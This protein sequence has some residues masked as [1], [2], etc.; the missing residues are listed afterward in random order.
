MDLNK[1]NRNKVISLSFLSVAFFYLLIYIG[2][3]YHTVIQKIP[4]ESELYY[5]VKKMEDLHYF[6]FL[7]AIVTVLFMIKQNKTNTVVS[8]K[9][10]TDNLTGAYNRDYLDAFF[11]KKK[12]QDYVFVMI[13]IDHFKKINDN[14]GHDVGDVVLRGMIKEI[15]RVIRSGSEDRIIRFGGEEFLLLLHI[16]SVNGSSNGIMKTIERVRSAV[17][18]IEFEDGKNGT[19]EITASYGANFISHKCISVDEAIAL[20]DKA[21][22]KAKV[23]RDCIMTYEVSH[24]REHDIDFKK[25]EDLVN[26]GKLLCFYQPVVELKTG[27]VIKYEALVRLEDEAGTI[28]TPGSFLHIVNN[29]KIR[30]KIISSLF[31][32]N[33]R[34]L[35]QNKGM[36]ISINLSLAEIYDD[37]VF[38]YIISFRH[39]SSTSAS[40]IEL[41]ILDVDDANNVDLLEERLL[42][43]KQL[44]FKI[45]IDDFGG[46]YSRIMHLLETCVDELKIDGSIVKTLKHSNDNIEHIKSIVKMAHL[47]GLSVTAG[48]I[49]DKNIEKIL[50]DAG[51]DQ[52]QGFY[53]GK[54]VRM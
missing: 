38:E 32:Y 51:V 40:R 23:D 42:T 6:V 16:P 17:K 13:D 8:K 53:I 15:N 27:R 35:E 25:I 5:L 37:A 21:L 33:A 50:I 9:A 19:I 36:F 11:K 24:L 43:L 12:I 41:E 30:L 28:F 26:K 45:S 47:N 52:G 1:K 20:A 31:E 10:F 39:L 18:K 29:E 49:E 3:L 44:G 14:F 34:S 48:Y 4:V 7:I 22:Y 46:K 2:Y 54:P